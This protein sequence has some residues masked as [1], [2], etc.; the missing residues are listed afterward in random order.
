MN[1]PDKHIPI[2][3]VGGG[4]VGLFLAI[5]CLKKGLTCRVLEQRKN[6]V[7][8]SRSL[9]IHP[10]SI[11]LFDEL[12]ITEPFLKAGLKIKKGL[13]LTRKHKLGEILFEQCP[14]PHNYILACPQFTTEKILRKELHK[15]DKNALITQA[16]FQH[17]TEHEY[18]VE[19]TYST[20]SQADNQITAAYLVGCDGK[21]SR[22]RKT[23][24]IH[25][26]GKRYKDTYMMGDFE[27]TTE[28]GSNAVIFL[29]KAGVIECFPL[30]NKMRRWVVKT[31][32][33]IEH[34]SK[35][36]LAAE[37]QA[38]IG[39]KLLE[40]Q[41]TMLSSFGVQHFMAETFA[42]GKILLAGDA[43]HVVSPI[44]GQGMNIGWLDAWELT[45]TL[46]RIITGKDDP[47][48]TQVLLKAYSDKQQK[49]HAES[50]AT[51]RTEYG[52]GEKNFSSFP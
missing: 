37:V 23:A 44:G 9:G 8:D 12:N 29:P 26:S 22:V 49:N 41:H 21:N 52:F 15:L 27:D 6:P 20:P 14:K 5:A 17:F 36:Q 24:S 19:V 48:H 13:A 39:Y 34:P 40:V 33:F 46:A 28:F 11:E 50:S 32:S 25:Y 42:K 4:P 35:Q 2:V 7:S 47:Y 10:T 18:G 30:P 16:E 3:I 1:A 31:S 43:A 38:R 45:R 51:S